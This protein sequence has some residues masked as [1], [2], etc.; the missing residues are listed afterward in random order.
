MLITTTLM[1]ESL[2]F[3]DL[4][5][6]LQLTVALLLPYRRLTVSDGKYKIEQFKRITARFTIMSEDAPCY[7][8]NRGPLQ[9]TQT[10]LRL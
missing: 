5:W 4:K 2:T 3:V 8:Y 1:L 7:T 6:S 10:Y 9:P